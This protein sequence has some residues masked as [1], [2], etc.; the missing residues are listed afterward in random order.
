[1]ELPP[2]F[3]SALNASMPRHGSPSLMVCPKCNGI[4]LKGAMIRWWMVNGYRFGTDYAKGHQ[5]LVSIRAQCGNAP[6]SEWV[7]LSRPRTNER[8][9]VHGKCAAVV[10]EMAEAISITGK[11]LAPPPVKPLRRTEFTHCSLLAQRDFPTGILGQFPRAYGPIHSLRAIIAESITS[12]RD[13]VVDSVARESSTIRCAA[14]PRI[15]T[16]TVN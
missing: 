3:V 16:R 4:V 7:G 1:M 15:L 2:Q 14:R 13:C 5:G 10:K 6:K 8:E 11:W 12:I 9:C